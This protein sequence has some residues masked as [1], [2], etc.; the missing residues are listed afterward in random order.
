MRS[1]LWYDKA[2]W[3]WPWLWFH[4]MLMLMLVELGIKRRDIQTLQT[5][6]QVV[7][8]PNRTYLLVWVIRRVGLGV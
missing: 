6:F 1:L 2:L 4:M 7:I 8:I 5:P 3:P